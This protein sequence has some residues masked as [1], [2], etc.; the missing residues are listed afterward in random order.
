MLV[1]ADLNTDELIAKRRN[2]ERIKEFSKQL[3]AFNQEAITQQPKLPSSTEQ[4][5]LN[6]AR[7]KYESNRQRALEFAKHIPKPKVTAEDVHG[8][9]EQAGRSKSAQR[10]RNS[11]TEN[12]SEGNGRGLVMDEDAFQM[13]KLQELEAK[14]QQS[15]AKMEAIK[16]SLHGF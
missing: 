8:D 13:A 9:T 16:K 4:S 11:S 10:R 6:I 2:A 3:R 1:N 15:K 5:D 14:H 7:A 12:P